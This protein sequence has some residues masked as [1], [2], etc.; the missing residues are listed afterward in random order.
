VKKQ[1]EIM[2]SQE[3]QSIPIKPIQ[4]TSVPQEIIQQLKFLIESGH[5]KPG[6]RLPSERKLARML[7]VSRP[8][9]REA[10]RALSLLGIVDNRPGSGTYLSSSPDNWQITPF[11]LLLTLNKG[12][13]LDIF[14]AR[15]SLEG[16]V[17]ALAAQR[18][19]DE[20]LKI[21]SRALKQMKENLDDTNRYGIYELQFHQAIV[22]ASKNLVIADLMEKIYRLLQEIRDRLYLHARNT[23]IDREQD[24]LLHESIFECIKTG[25]QKRA[26]ETMITHLQD[27][28]KELK[29]QLQQD[30]QKRSMEEHI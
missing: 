6:S 20:D 22:E 5:I 1:I 27:F 23:I 3:D 28:E 16:T 9:L 30:H 14:E 21:L 15:K 7:K 26:T 4:K 24:Y 18:R 11:S 13:L 29:A 12:M 10:L 17:A 8:S 2:N 25:D 19:T